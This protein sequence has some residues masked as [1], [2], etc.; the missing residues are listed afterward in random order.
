MRRLGF[1]IVLIALSSML[2]TATASAAPRSVFEGAWSSTDPVD[3]ST[4]HL[5]VVGGTNVQMTYV[6][7]LG[8]TCV[9]IAAPTLVFTGHLTGRVQGDDLFAWF[10]QGGC[11]KVQVINASI[12]FGW[13]FQYDR[14]TDT[15]FGAIQDGPATWYRD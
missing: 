6:D 11:G 3:G 12:R 1:A 8:T 10:K 4:Q 13:T 5:Y 2:G 9:E 7:E 15:M 14:A